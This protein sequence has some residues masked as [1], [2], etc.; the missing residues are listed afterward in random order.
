LLFDL[1]GDYDLVLALCIALFVIGA[2]LMLL[3]RAPRTLPP[4]PAR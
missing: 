2:A 4:D 3:V 1:T